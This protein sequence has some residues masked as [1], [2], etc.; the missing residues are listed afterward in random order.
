MLGNTN[1]DNLFLFRAITPK[2]SIGFVIAALC[3]NMISMPLF[4]SMLFMGM[5][6]TVAFVVT[7]GVTFVS[8]VI[9]G[10]ACSLLVA[11]SAGAIAYPFCYAKNSWQAFR[12]NRSL[13]KEAASQSD[14]RSKFDAL[15][16]LTCKLATQNDLDVERKSDMNMRSQ[17]EILSPVLDNKQASPQVSSGSL[18][19]GGLSQQ[20]K[21]EKNKM[22]A[23][24][25]KR[26]APP[27][28]EANVDPVEGNS[29]DSKDPLEKKI[30][31]HRSISPAEQRLLPEK[32][33][34]MFIN[35]NIYFWMVILH[36]LQYS[37]YWYI[38]DEVGS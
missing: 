36:Y 21:S 5:S 15:S 20:S 24:R 16:P 32:N 7:G 8:S 13:R 29:K 31:G 38:I 9:A 1:N 18:P 4:N 10:A 30:K 28:A 25:L 11:A 34:L 17:S 6:S 3:V 22:I 19:Q 35:K 14:N 23:A 33:R 12:Y 2:N 37:K 26:F 27:T